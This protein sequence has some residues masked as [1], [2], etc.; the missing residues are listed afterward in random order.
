MKAFTN[1][2]ARDAR[3][4]ATLAQQARAKG[5]V[6]VFAGGGSDLLGMMK[7]RLVTPDAYFGLKKL[8]FTIFE[9]RVRS[10]YQPV[11]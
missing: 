7:E 10:T 2:N 4:A 6:A 1:T 3:H 11:S 9:N 8:S 5:H